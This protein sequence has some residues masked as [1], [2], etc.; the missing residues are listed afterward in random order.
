MLNKA[1]IKYHFPCAGKIDWIGLR[2]YLS[3][4]VIHVSTAELLCGHGLVGDKAG[5]RKGSKRQITL[6]PAEYLPVI[7]S[8]ANRQT[9]FPEELRRNLVV[10]GM[11]LNIL[12]NYKLKI[13]TAVIEITGNCAP[14]GKM[15]HILG[16]GG[17]NAMRGHGG[18]TAKVIKG[19][20]INVG[21]T[22]EAII[23][24]TAQ[25]KLF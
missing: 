10:S 17:F 14:C 3:S 23:E 5:L 15:E 4:T 20:I 7:A 8:F 21:D 25:T 9:V 22:V 16:Y 24:E 6:I 2:Q 13:N 11:S 19:G 12:K 18:V 1:Y